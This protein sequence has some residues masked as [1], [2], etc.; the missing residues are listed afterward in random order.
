MTVVSCRQ[1]APRVGDLAGNCALSIAAIQAA[2]TEGA[3]IVVLPELVTTGYPFVSFDEVRAI[4][5]PAG[6][7]LFDAWSASLGEGGA[8]VIGGFA[9]LGADGRVYN[10]AAVVDA[11]GVRAVY[12]KLHLWD[13]EKTFFTPGSA[14]PPVV[15]TAQGRLGVMICYDMEFPELTRMTALNGADL[16]VVPTNWPIVDR[17]T[18][19]RPPEVIVA[20]AAARVNRMAIACCDRTGAE[21]GQEWTAGS[22]IIDEQG[23]IAAAT[24]LGVDAPAAVSATLDLALG[25]N[26]NHT[27]LSHALHDRR[28]DLYRPLVDER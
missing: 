6:H 9:E 27:V 25:R 1:L 8:V 4:A 26:K 15:D 16:L 28:P 22:T 18:G 10:S 23:W 24:P 2:V 13:L 14:L 5:L 17:P 21:R 3:D 11:S 19:E 20:M 7:P 12:R